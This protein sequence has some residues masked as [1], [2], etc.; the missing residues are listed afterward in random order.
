MCVRVGPVWHQPLLLECA[1][2]VLQA[3]GSKVFALLASTKAGGLGLNLCAAD[4]GTLLWQ[5]HACISHVGLSVCVCV[6]AGWAK[7]AALR[8]RSGLHSD[9]RFFQRGKQKRTRRSLVWV[10][11]Q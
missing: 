2:R 4:T 1:P 10:S 6:G 5:G 9:A 3:P 8:R 11:A 7:V